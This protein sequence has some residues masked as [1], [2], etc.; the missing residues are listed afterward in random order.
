M[1]TFNSHT[2]NP[3]SLP[4]DLFILPITL[5]PLKQDLGF[6]CS[7]KRNYPWKA[8]TKSYNLAVEPPKAWILAMRD[9]QR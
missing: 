6:L 3:T 7:R 2:I 8:N 4:L 9:L 5:F 1:Y